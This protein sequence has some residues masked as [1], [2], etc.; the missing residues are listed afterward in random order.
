MNDDSG[1]EAVSQ[2]YATPRVRHQGVLFNPG[3]CGD[4]YTLHL[5]VAIQKSGDDALL[6]RGCSIGKSSLLQVGELNPEA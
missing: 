2:A 4:I 1:G 3:N 5:T 6:C